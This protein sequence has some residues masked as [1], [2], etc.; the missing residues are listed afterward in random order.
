MGVLQ[1]ISEFDPFLKAHPEK[2]GNAGKGTPSHLSSKT[3]LGFIEVMGEELLAQIIS[4]IKVLFNRC[5]FHSECYAQ[6]P[7]HVHRAICVA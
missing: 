7:A 5:R 4:Q 3:Y 6:R 2:Y 1:V